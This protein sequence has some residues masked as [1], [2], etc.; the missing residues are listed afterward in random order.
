MQL[1]HGGPVLATTRVRA[2]VSVALTVAL[3]GLTACG[4]GDS[5]VERAQA[6]VTAKEKAVTKAEAEFSAAS[7]TFCNATKTYVVAIDRYGDILNATAPTVGDVETAGADLADPGQAALTGAEAAVEAQQSLAV[8]EQDL[9]DARAELK[10]VKAGST[11]SPSSPGSTPTTPT[12]TPL[13]PTA[14]VD[15]VTRA[16]SDFTSAQAAITHET[17]LAQASQQFNAAAVALEMAWL[18]LFADAGCLTDQQ[19]QAEDAVREYTREVQQALSDAGYYHGAVDG[20]YGPETVQAVEDLQ[21]ANGLPVTGAVDKATAAALQAELVAKGGV[22]AQQALATTAAVQQ[23]LK[24]AGFWDGPVDGAWT[25]ALTDAVK[26]FQTQLGVKP[27]GTV[28][29]A[30]VQALEKAIAE[31]AQPSAPPDSQA[32]S[33]ST[34]TTTAP[35]TPTGS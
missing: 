13:A 5:S 9:A 7:A 33:P 21:K 19:Q 27:T 15:R 30:T 16:E 14:T 25:P 34:P 6:R 24:L 2:V 17:P 10:Q 11:A 31:A 12:P 28:D 22:A 26:K 8:A 29:T 35:P 3:L 32:T 4:N 18:Q 20:V 23:T 1:C